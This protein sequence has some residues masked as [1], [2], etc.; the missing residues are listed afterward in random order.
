MSHVFLDGDDFEACLAFRMRP[1]ACAHTHSLP[2]SD[3]NKNIYTLWIATMDVHGYGPLL[4]R[5]NG[6]CES[7]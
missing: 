3:I 2:H 6:E 5:I 7:E 4:L 1:H